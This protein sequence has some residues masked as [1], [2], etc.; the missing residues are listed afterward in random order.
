MSLVQ[1]AS[2]VSVHDS[3]KRYILGSKVNIITCKD[4]IQKVFEWSERRE[5]RYICLAN[6]HM[7][8]EAYDSESFWKVLN[9]ADLT[10]PDGMSIVWSFRILG[11]VTQ[12]QICGRDLTLSICEEAAKRKISV[13]FYGSSQ[14]VL[15]A[16]VINLKQRYPALNIGYI[17]SP[18]FRPF[19]SEEETAIMRDIKTSGIQILFVGLGCPKQEYWMAKHKQ[20]FPGVMIGIGA[21][22][23]FL[24][25][26]KP[27]PPHWMQNMG[28]E[29]L[30]RLCLEPRRLWYRN[31]WH[32]PRLVILFALQVFQ[33]LSLFNCIFPTTWL[34]SSDF[35][36][37]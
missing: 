35:K 30:F 36:E 31:L 8:M 32:S 23:D 3:G 25:G 13:G 5:S 27:C 17:Y 24:S 14:E 21:A 18:P 37:F 29:W 12:K 4:A 16:L 22:F 26:F 2:Q 10:T 19:C 1:K 33:L 9:S 20:H 28:L 7:I 11:I 6:A 34:S 15:E